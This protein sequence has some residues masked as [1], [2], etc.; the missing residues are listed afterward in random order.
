MAASFDSKEEPANCSSSTNGSFPI[1]S[2]IRSVH[3]KKCWATLKGFQ[4]RSCRLIDTRIVGH[5]LSYTVGLDDGVVL[6]SSCYCG[7]NCRMG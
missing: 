6:D 2:S 1:S 7:L 3:S 5:H 4:Q